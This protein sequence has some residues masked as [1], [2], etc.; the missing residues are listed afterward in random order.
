VGAAAL[1]GRPGVISVE[2]GWRGFH[3]VNRV[4][5]DPKKVTVEQMKE[6]LRQA[7]TYIRTLQYPSNKKN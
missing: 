1:D 4:V 3:E 6:W 5:Y 7:G 2:K